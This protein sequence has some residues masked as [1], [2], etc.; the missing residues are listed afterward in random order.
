MDILFSNGVARKRK[1]VTF[2]HG[3]WTDI[4]LLSQ[5]NP[6]HCLA[7]HR[8]GSEKCETGSRR[9]RNK[10]LKIDDLVER[11]TASHDWKNPTTFC[12]HIAIHSLNYSRSMHSVGFLPRYSR[13]NLWERDSKIRNSWKVSEVCKNCQWQVE[14]LT[15][16][17]F[18]KDLEHWTAIKGTRP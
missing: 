5:L 6:F 14:W 1:V 17:W 18:Q 2:R 4:S 12:R 16:R 15:I 3:Q 7:L 9:L 10:A 8:F 11:A 13:G